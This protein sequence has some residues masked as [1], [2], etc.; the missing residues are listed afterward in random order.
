MTALIQ[1][2]AEES[3]ATTVPVNCTEITKLLIYYDNLM[4]IHIPVDQ[5]CL[6]I[7]TNFLTNVLLFTT[8]GPHGD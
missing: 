2:P 1:S 7:M 4:T 3:E 5:K 6:F 8:M